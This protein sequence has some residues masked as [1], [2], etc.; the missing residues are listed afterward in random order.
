MA[1]YSSTQDF[2]PYVD[3][4]TYG[5]D[6]TGDTS[7]ATAA[8]NTVALQAALNDLAASSNTGRGG[9]LYLPPGKIVIN[10]TL[11]LPPINN[12]L[13]GGALIG[14]GHNAT[15]LFLRNGSNADM[16]LVN[17]QFWTIRDFNMDGN[18]PNQTAGRC[19]VSNFTKT[20]IQ[21]MYIANAKSHG[22]HLVGAAQPA[23]AALLSNLYIISCQGNGINA[24]TQAYDLKASNIW[25]GSSGLANVAINSTQQHWHNLHAWGGAAEGVKI[26]AGDQI[27]FTNCYFE[28][29]ASH[30]LSVNNAKG[31][32]VSATHLRGNVGNGAYLF[33]AP[34][35]TFATCQITDNSN[36][37]SN[38]VGIQGDGTSTDVMVHGCYFGINND[39]GVTSH[40]AYA[41]KTISS[42]DRWII[43]GNNMRASQHAT[44]SSSLVGAANVTANNIT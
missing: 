26:T 29:N 10:N 11:T 36:G 12:N 3:A 7:K 13:R 30:G 28:T 14:A 2:T 32:M 44:G 38:Q 21:N 33:N 43:T 9:A 39:D 18:Y 16:I 37:V 15:Q 24:D 22:I 42:C 31:I 8:A 6:N 27:R 25:I 4:R 34:Q 5:V 17:G 35:C 20:I 40:Q 41:V 23:H 19:I 1:V